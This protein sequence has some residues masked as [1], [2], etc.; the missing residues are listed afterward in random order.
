LVI[1]GGQ[2]QVQAVCLVL[3]SRARSAWPVGRANLQC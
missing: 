2:R 1:H 3:V